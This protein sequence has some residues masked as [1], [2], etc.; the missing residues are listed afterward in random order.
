MRVIAVRPL[1]ST[2]GG[3]VSAAGPR[4]PGCNGCARA[5]DPAL[6]PLLLPVPGLSVAQ[7]PVSPRCADCPLLLKRL[8]AAPLS[9]LRRMWTFIIG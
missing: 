8:T 6:V 9:L 2:D 3:K 4:A 7:L 5:S 1:C